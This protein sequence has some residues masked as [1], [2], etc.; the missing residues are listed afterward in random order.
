MNDRLVAGKSAAEKEI[1]LVEDNPDDA[2][3]TR[4]AFAE[5]GGE[6][7]LRVVADGAAAVAYL[8]RCTP[9]E[10]PALVLLDLNLPKLNGREVLQ[11][12]RAEPATRSLPVVVLTTSAEPFDVD[13]AYALGANSYIQKPVEFD[14]FVEVVRQV[15]RYWLAI[16]LPPGRC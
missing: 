12:I 4:I 5:A 2:E 14:R 1:L 8:Q 13:Q 6:Y 9:A 3:L 11:A 7:D 15:G 10:L 16:N